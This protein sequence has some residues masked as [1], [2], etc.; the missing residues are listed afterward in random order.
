MNEVGFLTEKNKSDAGSTNEWMLLCIMQLLAFCTSFEMFNYWIATS[1][2]KTGHAVVVLICAVLYPLLML[3]LKK[4]SNRLAALVLALP[5]AF[6]GLFFA[7]T[8]SGV[9][10]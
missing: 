7:I 4:T 9:T 2:S 6:V 1:S 5:S 3:R 8:S 10:H